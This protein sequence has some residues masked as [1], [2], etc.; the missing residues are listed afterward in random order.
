[1]DDPAVPFG[2]QVGVEVGHNTT[3]LTG[4]PSFSA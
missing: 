3:R 2:G 4:L 1:V